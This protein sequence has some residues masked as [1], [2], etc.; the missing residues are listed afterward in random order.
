MRLLLILALIPVL[1][2]GQTELIRNGRF[3]TVLFIPQD[4]QQFGAVYPAAGWL[5]ENT[6]DLFHWQSPWPVSIPTNQYG[7]TD[8]TDSC[9]AG[10]LGMYWGDSTTY[11]QSGEKIKQGVGPVNAGTMVV[12]SFD[13]FRAQWPG[14]ACGFEVTLGSDTIHTPVFYDTAW[15]SFDTTIT[16]SS[17]ADTIKIGAGGNIGPYPGPGI[18]HGFYY[19]DNISLTTD[20]TTHLEEPAG[21]HQWVRHATI[22]PFEVFVCLHCGRRQKRI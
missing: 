1:C 18:L 9:H 4:L 6:A 8:T 10:F 13:V 15:V 14:P 22:I 21:I 19:I 20:A 17:S 2:M 7:T 12:L 3:D 16:L 11:N 5:E